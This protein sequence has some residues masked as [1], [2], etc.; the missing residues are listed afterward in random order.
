MACLSRHYNVA[1]DDLPLRML[2]EFEN[3]PGLRLT[4]SQA[5][6]LWDLPEADCRDAL[7][8]LV[9]SRLLRRDAHGRYCLP[10]ASR[11]RP[12]TPR[13]GGARRT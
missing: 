1:I 13:R 11:R 6:G 7:A 8:Y 12:G 9:G 5:R 4:F 2:L 3:Q 10:A